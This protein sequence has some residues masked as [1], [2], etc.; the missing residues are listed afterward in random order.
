[1]RP[2]TLLTLVLL[3]A[4]CSASSTPHADAPRAGTD[5]GDDAPQGMRELPTT[6]SGHVFTSTLTGSRSAHQLAQGVL[7]GMQQYFGGTARL[8]QA[9]ADP[10][11]ARLQAAF[12]AELRGQP[13][14]GMMT[15]DVAG[16]SA[17]AVVLFD[18]R[19]NFAGSIDQLL[20]VASG[21]AGPA[22]AVPASEPMTRTPIPD[23]SGSI[24]LA[25]GWAIRY[26]QKGAIDISGP[27]PGAGMSLGA[28][29]SMPLSSYDPVEA[30]QRMTEAA[31]RQAGRQ[32]DLTVLDSRPMEWAQ[33]GRAAL[34]R[35][36]VIA[37]GQAMDYF[38]L[39]GVT[40]FEANQVFLYTSYIQARSQDFARVL[41]VALR[42]WGSW[43]IN[44]AV[45]SQRLQQA[46][47]SMRETG[48]LL[49]G[50]GGSSRALAGLNAGWGQYIRGVATLED[51]DRTRSEVDQR[52]AESVVQADPNGFRIVPTNEL[53]P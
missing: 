17:R 1:M 10:A 12:S 7:Q 6:G 39:I 42:S 4:A 18:A 47:Q 2:A 25:Q 52:F 5:T 49:A 21:G 16:E 40:P 14:L 15:I 20:Q 53:V 22:G 38:A 46:A 33:G 27:M 29:A 23:G 3:L 34:V 45:L 19:R 11:D 48:E 41:P 30:L 8:L 44:P 28:V 13:V 32:F 37:D 26:A 43:S 31:A 36:R 24:D 50:G 35:Y 9:I 51:G